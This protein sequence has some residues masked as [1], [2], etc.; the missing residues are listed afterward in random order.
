MLSLATSSFAHRPEEV[1]KSG[2]KHGVKRADLYGCL[3]FHLQDSLRDFAA[4]LRRFKISLHLTNSDLGKLSQA[5]SKGDYESLGLPPTMKFD[6][7]EVS[8]TID[9]EYLGVRNVLEKWG[10]KLKED[11][12]H[13]TL[14]AYSMNWSVTERGAAS[15]NPGLLPE[16]MSKLFAEGDGEWKS[17]QSTRRT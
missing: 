14:F 12:S 13:A 7:V 10:T 4:R 15:D 11:N 5:I 8:N 3:Y 6:R 2:L 9:I 16:L 1:L 17:R